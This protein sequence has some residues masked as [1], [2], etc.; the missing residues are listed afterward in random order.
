MHYVSRKNSKGGGVAL[1]INSNLKCRK[2]ENQ[3]ICV[4]ENFEC[5]TVELLLEGARNVIVSCL[6]RKPGA[7]LE[8]FIEKLEELYCHIKNN[9]VLYICG[10]FNIDLLKQDSH[11]PTET[12]LNT[13]FSLGLFPLITKPS[14]VTAH[15]ATLIDNIF[16]NELKH[17]NIS[18]V[19]LNDISDHLPVFTWCGCKIKKKKTDRSSDFI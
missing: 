4:E 16:T 9:K 11:A 12:F 8:D 19:I 5:V 14:R 10:D 2:V 18:G 7:R 13:M 3:S 1:Y 6:Y 17:E 15:S